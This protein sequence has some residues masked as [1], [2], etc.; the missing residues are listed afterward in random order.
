[1]VSAFVIGLLTGVV[2]LFAAA[3]LTT[4]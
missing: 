3:W 1:V 4:P 2:G